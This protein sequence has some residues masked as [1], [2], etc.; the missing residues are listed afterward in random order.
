MINEFELKNLKFVILRLEL[1]E[2]TNP[3]EFIRKILKDLGYNVKKIVGI[4]GHPD[5]E[6]SM[7]NDTFY[8]EAKGD[9][10]GLKAEQIKWIKDNPEKKV[11][12]FFLVQKEQKNKIVIIRKKE[13]NKKQEFE[14]FSNEA[15]KQIEKM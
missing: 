14:N 6:V 2:K 3:E 8:V 7:D 1:F 11:Y 10:D 13:E 4:L 5:F 15:R 9:N 12:C